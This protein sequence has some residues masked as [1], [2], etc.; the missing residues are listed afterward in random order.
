MLAD[1]VLADVGFLEKDMVHAGSG[2]PPGHKVNTD[3]TRGAVF[4]LWRDASAITPVTNAKNVEQVLI[5]LAEAAGVLTGETG[6]ICQGQRLAREIPAGHRVRSSPCGSIPKRCS[7]RT[8]A[9]TRNWL[10]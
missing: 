9:R 7:S 2:S 4:F 5:D 3:G 8:L 1:I 6:L 10:T